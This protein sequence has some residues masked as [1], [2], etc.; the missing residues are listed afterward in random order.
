MKAYSKVFFLSRLVEENRRKLAVD[1][2]NTLKELCVINVRIK[3]TL[4]KTGFLLTDYRVG[5]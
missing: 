5:N 2:A 1:V 3:R 4:S